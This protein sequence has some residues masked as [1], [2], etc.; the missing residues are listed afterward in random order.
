VSVFRQRRQRGREHAIE[1][2]TRDQPMSRR[3]EMHV[4]GAGIIGV[5]HEQVNVANYGG[6]IREVANIRCP[7]VH[8]TGS[9][10]RPGQLDGFA[11]WCR[12]LREALDLAFYVG[13]RLS[14][15]DRIAPINEREIVQGVVQQS[16]RRRDH[17]QRAAGHVSH[18]AYAVVYQIVSRYPIGGCEPMRIACP[19]CKKHRRRQRA[20]S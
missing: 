1:A 16:I 11:S 9:S 17:T 2:E 19:L 8:V 6:L 15:D 18:R 7:F 14:F 20:V 4:A 13:P 10:L 5:A 3:L 12:V